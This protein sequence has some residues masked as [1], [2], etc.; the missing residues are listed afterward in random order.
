MPDCTYHTCKSECQ[1]ECKAKNSYCPSNGTEGSY[2]IEE[3][4]MN[5]LHCDPD[6]NGA[7][8]CEILLRTMCFHP[9][10]PDYPREWIYQNEKPICAK[11]QKWD[12]GNDGDPDDT[13][14]PN[15]PPDP[16]DPSQLNLFPL[17]PTELELLPTPNEQS[18]STR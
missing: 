5:C 9:N 14:N 7:K 15:R 6:P 1:T 3:Y 16:P 4:C 10:E 18:I 11:F 2:F 17:Y 13:D 8:Q 12:W